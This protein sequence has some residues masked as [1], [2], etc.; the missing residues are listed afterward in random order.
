M[1]FL[2]IRVFCTLCHGFVSLVA[3][4]FLALVH[5]KVH[6]GDERTV[7]INDRS[8]AGEQ[9]SLLPG[10]SESEDGFSGLGRVVEGS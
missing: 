7:D 2:I 5:R 10:R 9:L 3:Q 8:R 6:I 1:Y 4:G